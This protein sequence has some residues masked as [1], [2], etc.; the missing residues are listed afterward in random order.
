M[1]EIIV[2]TE[3][4]DI[5]RICYGVLL[6]VDKFKCDF[7]TKCNI[8]YPHAKYKKY[9]KN[10]QPDLRVLKED[11]FDTYTNT[12]IPKKSVFYGSHVVYLCSPENYTFKLKT[13]GDCFSGM[14]I[15]FGR[16]LDEIKIIY[17]S[18]VC[19]NVETKVY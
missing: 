12:L 19:D 7:N 17:D 16:L 18:Y 15:E 3:Y 13:T 4:Q 9:N 6:V 5:Y 8:Y 14:P 2:Q 1:H 10:C 11:Y